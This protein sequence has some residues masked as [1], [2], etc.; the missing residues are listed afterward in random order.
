[1]KAAPNAFLAYQAASE[2]A[3]CPKCEV[4]KQRAHAKR[5]QEALR[6]KGPKKQTQ[7]KGAAY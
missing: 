7:R 3:C 5:R 6:R 4:A 1:M 2:P